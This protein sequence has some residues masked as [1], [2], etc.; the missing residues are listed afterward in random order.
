M[1]EQETSQISNEEELL[2]DLKGRFLRDY[3]AK[4]HWI[5]K[6]REW[7]NFYDSEQWTS[8][9]IRVLES[10]SQPVVT[11]NRIKPKVDSI[12]GMELGLKV[13][14]K[15]FDKGTGDFELAK[16]ISEGMRHV[17]TRNDFD[18]LESEAFKDQIIDGL[19]WY[20]VGL[21][22]ED[23]DPEITISHL[24]N[25]DVFEDCDSKKDD[26]SDAKQ[27]SKSIWTAQEDAIELFPGDK[28]AIDGLMENP[29]DA[30]PVITSKKTAQDQYKYT[31]DASVPVDY[32]SFV[33]KKLRRVRLT[34]TYYRTSFR[35]QFLT[36]SGLGVVE[37]TAMSESDVT[38]TKDSFPNAVTWEQLG[39]KLNVATFCWNKILE[40]KKDVAAWDLDA[41]FP[42]VKVPGHRVRNKTKPGMY[43]GL[44]KQM[45]DPQREVNKRRSKML[46]L[47]STN[48]IQMEKGAVDD[49]ELAR[50]EAARADALLI[51]NPGFAF[52]WR[53]QLDLAQ[54]QF[55]LLQESKN[56]IDNVGIRG[57]IEGV[58][59]ATSGRD[60]QLRQ[61]QA[62]QSLREMFANAR[63]ARRRV[64]LIVLDFM[65]QF[66][67]NQKL[68]R[69]TDDPEAG[70]IV[71]NK[72]VV[73]PD[74]VERIE[75]NVSLGKYDIIVEEAP[76]TVT[77][78]G[79]TFEILSNL[80]MKGLP[81]PMDMLIES[82]PIPNKKRLLERIQQQQEQQA[83]MA[84]AGA[85]GAPP[86]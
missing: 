74:G 46:H 13:N 69:I 39:H 83:Q 62:T 81:I 61:Q 26:L 75:N 53:P 6:K 82:S 40:H 29:A 7:S 15:A 31:G 36:A 42:L 12:V 56:E 45:M 2:K 79:E 64:F 48:Q 5:Q 19:G 30:D 10:R 72:K 37:T 32:A 47:L 34:T 11:I 14:T 73:D 58:S 80:A 22:W 76:E 25:E 57:E 38:K 59:K 68:I 20:E 8:E 27:I 9:E 86:Q 65:Q 18:Q 51:T 66:W 24:D 4:Q 60:F 70:T 1:A 43:Y 49:V 85:A 54:S 33:D 52:Q 16:F 67:T 35:R 44:V 55:Q 63:G 17:E 41:K 28:D 84:Q 78:Q 3:H 21:R 50:S 71:L 77:L 23:L